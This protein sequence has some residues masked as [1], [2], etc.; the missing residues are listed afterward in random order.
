M[1]IVTKT[2][3]PDG[4]ILEINSVFNQITVQSLFGFL[5]DNAST[6]YNQE[7]CYS[8]D[9][10]TSFT[11]YVALT[12]SN[13][14]N[15]NANPAS[16]LVVRY[17]YVQI[18]SPVINQDIV[19]KGI[20]SDLVYP[21]F[22]NS[23]FKE[24]FD[25]N[26][27]NVLNWALNVLEKLYDR[28]I[29]PFYVDRNKGENIFQDEDYI[30]IWVTIC[31]FYAILVIYGRQYLNIRDNVILLRFFFDFI[32]LFYN[33]NNTL[34]ELQYLFDNYIQE[35]K[36][37]GTNKIHVFRDSD[38]EPSGELLRLIDYLYPDEF[39]F[40]HCKPEAVGWNIGN[41]SPCYRGTESIINAIKGYEFTD[42][43]EDPSKYPLENDQYITT[44]HITNGVD[45]V[46]SNMDGLADDWVGSGSG[47]TYSIVSGNGFSVK[48]QRVDYPG[49][50]PSFFGV[51]QNNVVNAGFKAKLK[52]KYRSDSLVQIKFGS[53]TVASYPVNEGEAKSVEFE[54]VPTMTGSIS[55]GAL[56]DIGYAE[57]GDISLNCGLFI[58]DIPDG[59]FSG[60]SEVEDDTKK[61][62]VSPELNYEVSFR[63]KK[64]DSFDNVSFGVQAYDA[65]ENAIN[66]VS[67]IDG[68]SSNDFFVSKNVTK[69]TSE[70]YW[71]RGVIYNKDQPDV[72][73]NDALLNVG[74][75]K[76][77]RMGEKVAFIIP[78]IRIN[79]DLGP[80]LACIRDIKIRPA[81]LPFSL[82][83]LGAKN[84]IINWVL[85]RS[86]IP[87]DKVSQIVKQYLI[88]YNSV[89]FPI[90]LTVENLGTQF[91]KLNS[92][93][94]LLLNTGGRIIL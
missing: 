62:I 71:V 82:G 15:V 55:L 10:G 8:V 29:T 88:P 69:V 77:L 25:F 44:N 48:A 22:E 72:S 11:S 7:F 61:I 83:Y 5:N 17:K 76:N 31:H 24:F 58:Q 38:T 68:S 9:G 6:Y 20:Y 23:L 89:Y 90:Y 35:F 65:Q 42:F 4:A 50:L 53:V 74:Y 27:H 13:I 56:N 67:V 78:R 64:N 36:D 19:I 49:F 91:L 60:V 92:G 51:I 39:I 94:Y 3:I 86:G 59:D 43:V 1:A 66:L 32:G 41:S 2:D 45:F 52:F 26:D 93:G 33:A 14:R 16:D 75:G 46:D 12:E 47:N 70:E 87:N 80:N 81:N 79:G 57:F 21:Y 37:R 30:S 54:F 63:I 34:E 84:F 18:A 28:G 85:N 40:A 73:A